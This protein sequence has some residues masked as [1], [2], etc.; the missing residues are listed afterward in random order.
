ME[1]YVFKHIKIKQKNES[2]N[3][4][5]CLGVSQTLKTYNFKILNYT[6]Y[7]CIVL[8]IEVVLLSIADCIQFKVNIL[9]NAICAQ[10]YVHIR[11]V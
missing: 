11:V 7:G 10:Q 1:Y 2:I 8:H 3:L 9:F 4:A 6:D 5:Y